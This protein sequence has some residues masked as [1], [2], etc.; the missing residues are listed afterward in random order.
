M[1]GRGTTRLVRISGERSVS[2]PVGERELKWGLTSGNS[3]RMDGSSL[4][5]WR[6]DIEGLGMTPDM[7]GRKQGLGG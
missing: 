2:V 1:A 5:S 3:S 6:T 7:V 4:L